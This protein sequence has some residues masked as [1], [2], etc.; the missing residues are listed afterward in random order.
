MNTVEQW[1]P[2]VGFEGLYSVSD[3]GRVRS[4]PRFVARKDGRKQPIPGR[5]KKA[6]VDGKGYPRVAL[7]GPAFPKGAHRTVHSLVMEAFI[8]PCPDGMEIC[9]NDGDRLNARL[10]NLRYGTRSENHLDKRVHGTHNNGKKT[11]CP[12]GHPYDET[13]T[14]YI[15]NTVWRQ[16]RTCMRNRYYAKQRG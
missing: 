7:Y 5:I 9:H 12:Q 15:P 11:H 4:E 16:C 1:R 10:S 6:P 3:Q 13:N 14:Y 8:G 2:V